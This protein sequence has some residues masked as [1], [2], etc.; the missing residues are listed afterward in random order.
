[1]T[2][3]QELTSKITPVMYVAIDCQNKNPALYP[4]RD[5]IFMLQLAT[6][7]WKD[8]QKDLEHQGVGTGITVEETESTENNKIVIP[9]LIGAGDQLNYIKQGLRDLGHNA[10]EYIYS[11]ALP[12]QALYNL[13]QGYGK[14]MDALYSAEISTHYYE[15]LRTKTGN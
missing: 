14:V 11:A 1:M 12:P 13:K 6:Y 5:A 2:N 3:I 8:A 10:F 15:Q 9:T 4:L 7:W